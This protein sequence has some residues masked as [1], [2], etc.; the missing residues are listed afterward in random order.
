MSGAM[1]LPIVFHRHYGAPLRP[2]RR[3]PMSKYGYLHEALVARGLLPAT[4]CLLSNS[5]ARRAL[6]AAVRPAEY[7]AR[8]AGAALTPEEARRMGLPSIE[9]AALRAFL[10]AASTLLAARLALKAGIAC[11]M[12][13][14]SHYADPAGV[15][16]FA[17]STCRGR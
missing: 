2:G 10:T 17:S 9:A 15:R 3:F 13:G 12:A 14:G 11:N 6:V 16:G 5:P 7:V 8:I 1:R 4:G